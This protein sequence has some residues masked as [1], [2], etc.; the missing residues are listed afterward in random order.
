MRVGEN[1]GLS[2]HQIIRFDLKLESKIYINNAMV[3][4]FRKANWEGFVGKMNNLNCKYL[5]HKTIHTNELLGKI[6]SSNLYG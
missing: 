6:R 2:N 5:F 1:F 3:P 4:D